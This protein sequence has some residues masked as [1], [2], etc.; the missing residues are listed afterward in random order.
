MWTLLSRHEQP[1][2][3]QI[4]KKRYTTKLVENKQQNGHCWLQR[5]KSNNI[6][7]YP[8]L[9]I[10]YQLITWLHSFSFIIKGCQFAIG[11]CILFRII[12]TTWDILQAHSFKNHTPTIREETYFDYPILQNISCAQFPRMQI[13]I[14]HTLYPVNILYRID[15]L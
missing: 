6:L 11:G 2:A 4:D 8:C 10:V 5:A 3:E 1:K 7:L 12:F 14:P 15:A 13:V 9:Q